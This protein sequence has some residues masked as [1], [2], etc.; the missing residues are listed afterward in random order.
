MQ[1]GLYIDIVIDSILVLC[2]QYCY[3]FLVCYDKKARFTTIFGFSRSHIP[4]NQIGLILLR[5]QQFDKSLFFFDMKHPSSR[6]LVQ[7]INRPVKKQKTLPRT[8][9]SLY[10]VFPMMKDN[11]HSLITKRTYILI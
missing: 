11:T 10:Q 8:N 7:S 2:Q 4:D 3:F 5:E 9:R 1:Q 6:V